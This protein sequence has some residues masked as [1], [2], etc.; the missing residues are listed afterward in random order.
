MWHS[1]TE[2]KIANVVA[3]TGMTEERARALVT[4]K[5][6]LSYRI[7]KRSHCSVRFALEVASNVHHQGT[8]TE[9]CVCAECEAA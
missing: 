8:P 6:R 7:K 1:M 5:V 3:H 9:A 4:G 2:A